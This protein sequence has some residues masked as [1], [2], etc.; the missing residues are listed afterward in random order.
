LF[1]VLNNN[2]FKI[3]LA[4]TLLFAGI[5]LRIFPIK[6]RVQ[7][8][9]SHTINNSINSNL[10]SYR[11]TLLTNLVLNFYNN[12]NIGNYKKAFNKAFE[13]SWSKDLYLD[14]NKN[15]DDNQVIGFT[16]ES[17]LINR[18]KKELGDRGE[19]LSIF[20][21]KVVR[22]IEVKDISI[23]EKFQDINLLRKLN[24]FREIEKYYIANVEGQIYSSFCSHSK[25]HKLL[26]IVKF[27]GDNEVRVFL[28]GAKN[29]V[30]T[31]TLEWFVNR[32][33]G[34]FIKL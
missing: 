15:V 22:L 7:Y 31:N 23:Y 34:E 32:N 19:R 6:S 3:F 30:G 13:I 1:R 10:N 21:I 20:D 29:L 2:Y 26:V 5:L 28:N 8:E 33:V 27:K 16:D 25:W 17:L 14:T 12:L 24:Y 9:K 11:E 4:I 18:T